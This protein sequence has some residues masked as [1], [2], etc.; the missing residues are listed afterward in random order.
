MKCYQPEL[1]FTSKIEDKNKEEFVKVVALSLTRGATF[2]VTIMGVN[3]NALINTDAMR[4]CTSGTFYN[5]LLLKAF[6][7][8]CLLHLVVLSVQWILHNV[9]LN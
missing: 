5:Q 4:S 9:Y 1:Y 3:C 8:L 6:D 7:V 2:L